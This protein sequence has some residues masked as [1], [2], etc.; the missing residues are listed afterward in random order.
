MT[1]YALFKRIMKKKSF[2]GGVPLRGRLETFEASRRK[3]RACDV[4]GI[5][6]GGLRLSLPNL[7]NFFTLGRKVSL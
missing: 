7:Y 1:F 3:R 5:S 2:C 6:Q 4:M